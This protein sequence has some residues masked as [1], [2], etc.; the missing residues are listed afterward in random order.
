MVP[1]GVAYWVGL[2]QREQTIVIIEKI[3]A[4]TEK[5]DRLADRIP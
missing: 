2:K 4:L 1:A 3:E 5:V